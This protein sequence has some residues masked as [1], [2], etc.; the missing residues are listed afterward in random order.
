[1]CVQFDIIINKFY[2]RLCLQLMML[3]THDLPSSRWSHLKPSK[4]SHII[5][6]HH[7]VKTFNTV[8][9]L[10]I[11]T[12]NCRPEDSKACIL[13]SIPFSPP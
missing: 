12:N 4:L 9:P 2:L 7:W 11:A 6:F 8:S 13:K 1:M 3:K 10:I 5:I